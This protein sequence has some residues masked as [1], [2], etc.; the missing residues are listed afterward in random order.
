MN[1]SPWEWVHR[2]PGEKIHI[3]SFLM[4]RW[5]EDGRINT[6]GFWERSCLEGNGPAENVDV[7]IG[8]H[9]GL[10]PGMGALSFGNQSPQ[11]PPK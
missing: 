8:F 4:G 1:S 6:G 5:D 2:Q 9:G 3:S 7:R 10:G 11:L